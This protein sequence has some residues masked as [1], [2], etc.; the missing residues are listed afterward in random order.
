MT[1][2]DVSGTGLFSHSSEFFHVLGMGLKLVAGSFMI[3]LL[4]FTSLIGAVVYSFMRGYQTS[5]VLHGAR[6]LIRMAAYA[7]GASIALVFALIAGLFFSLTVAKL[8]MVTVLIAFVVSF[9]VR[10]TFLFLVLKRFGKYV[11]YFTVLQYAKEKV[12]DHAQ[13][14][15]QP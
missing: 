9:V 1:L 14:E 7:I 15:N 8:L 4:A 11:M 5:S 12:Y 13:Q 2:L 10:E 6:T 3:V